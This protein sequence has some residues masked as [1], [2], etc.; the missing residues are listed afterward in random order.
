MFQAES[1]IICQEFFG[2]IQIKKK[3]KPISSIEYFS[4]MYLPGL[5][6][7]LNRVCI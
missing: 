2:I 6:V 7:N 3:K 4:Q 1:K 5:L